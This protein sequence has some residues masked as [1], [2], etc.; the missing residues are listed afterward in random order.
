MTEPD[1]TYTATL[2]G[3]V[4]KP[5]PPRL[6][7]WARAYLMERRRALLTEL[8]AIEAELGIKRTGK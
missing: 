7:A 3:A 8:R 6:P 1:P 4:V 5:E 2:S